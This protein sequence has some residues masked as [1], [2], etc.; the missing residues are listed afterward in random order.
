MEA[1]RSA[2]DSRA[3]SLRNSPQVPPKHA[4]ALHDKLV[5]RLLDD[6]LLLKQEMEQDQEKLTTVKSAANQEDLFAL[7]AT[8][9]VGREYAMRIKPDVTK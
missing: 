7:V 4:L 5:L 1:L 8:M 6:M 2:V 3:A 9:T